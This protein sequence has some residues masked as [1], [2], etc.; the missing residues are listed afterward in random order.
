MMA[1]PLDSSL[2][3][4]TIRSFTLR[5]GLVLSG[6]LLWH[7]TGALFASEMPGHTAPV[8]LAFLE[9]ALAFALILLATRRELPGWAVWLIPL[10][11]LCIVA[12]LSI[13]HATDVYRGGGP[14]MTDIYLNAEYAASL[15]ARGENPFVYDM[16]AAP[17]A[18]GMRY[19]ALTPMLRN[20]FVYS[21]GYSPLSFMLL[22][23]FQ[24]LN[25]PS[26]YV[27][28]VCFVIAMGVIFLGVPAPLRPVILLPFMAID[29]LLLSTLMGVMDIVW[30]LAVLLMIV[31]WPH[32][33]RRAVLFGLACAVKPQP[34]LLLPFLLIRIWKETSHRPQERRQE[35]AVFLSLTGFVFLV[36][37]LPFLSAS[38]GTL[39]AGFL[40]NFVD[41]QMT[42][43]HGLSR[44]T[45][46]GI[47]MIPRSVFTIM[48][49]LVY[50]LALVLYWRHFKDWREAMWLVPGIT[51]WFAYRSLDHYWVFLAMPLLFAV[52]RQQGEQV[53]MNAEPAST[54]DW[55]LSAGAFA[56]V[57]AVITGIVLWHAIRPNPLTLEIQDPVYANTDWVGE[58]HLHVTNTSDRS[59]TPRFSVK[60]N[61]Q[62]FFWNIHEGPS[63]L[64]PGQS[65]DFTVRGAWPA[66]AF[67]SRN[68]AEV[69]VTDANS[70]D[71]RAAA[72]VAP[73]ITPAYS[74]VIPNG[75]YRFWRSD[76]NAPSYWGLIAE[77]DNPDSIERV[78]AA[79]GRT[80][81]RFT[82]PANTLTDVPWS[83]V[84]MDTQM[85]FPEI[86]IELWVQPPP[87]ANLGPDFATVYGVELIAND[88]RIWVLFG[89][90]AA[91]GQIEPDLYYWMTPAPR[92]EWSL[93]TLNIRQI[94]ADLGFY[95][96]NTEQEPVWR[97]DDLGYPRTALTFRLLL[98]NRTPHEEPVSAEF[99]PLNSTSLLP[100]RDFL[101]N[102]AIEQP[103]TMLLWRGQ[104]NRE[105]GNL[106]IAFE[107]FTRAIEV[108]PE[109]AHAYI[110]LGW[111]EYDLG[112]YELATDYFLQARQ[113]IIDQPHR[114]DH[115]DLGETYDG[116]IRTMIRSGACFEG[117]IEFEQARTRLLAISV[118]AAEVEMCHP[119]GVES[120]AR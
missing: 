86:P 120:P 73:D 119:L 44:L 3:L 103:E 68:G 105:A 67:N 81:L 60:E 45:E 74:G 38:P 62:P 107:F 55:R 33:I 8:W 49:A 111:V 10:A 66:W 115:S 71:L 53:K 78:A 14:A 54:F 93:Q 36:F 58:L 70:Y 40:S 75:D 31:H 48:M 9:F 64:D 34:F 118:T 17:R 76:Q 87:E 4:E 97:F 39:L 59:L 85:L 99:G 89:D 7:H 13:R 110:G 6:M 102:E 101:M 12:N 28:L 77:P 35:L 91:T 65:A 83:S 29:G 21:Y 22:L 37:Y 46:L 23:P 98:A 114:Y 61:G 63:I 100:D 27:Y 19:W 50:S 2:S 117:A 108:A 5:L 82:I 15:F 42:I 57:A 47:V 92:G 24:W 94:F 106:G 88:K 16:F 109:E 18:L 90:Q 52:A 80:N 96:R 113:M 26:H 51:F 11:A 30:I 43:G 69:I 84:K 41:Q 32:R 20:D 104:K 112:V 1:L 25:I 116:I 95:I 72:L 56:S 79:D